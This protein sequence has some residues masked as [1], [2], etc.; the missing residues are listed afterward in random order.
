MDPVIDSACSTACI[1]EAFPARCGVRPSD[2]PNGRHPSVA[3]GLEAQY[4]KDGGRRAGGLVVEFTD[5][6]CIELDYA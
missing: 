6:D 2:T 1:R 5:I 3:E 4:F